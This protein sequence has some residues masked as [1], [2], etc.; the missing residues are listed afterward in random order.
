ME[1]ASAQWLTF[2]KKL[3][4]ARAATHPKTVDGVTCEVY[5]NLPAHLTPPG[6]SALAWTRTIRGGIATVSFEE[7]ADEAA[8]VKLVGDYE[9]LASLTRFIVTEQNEAE[10]IGEMD[11]AVRAGRITIVRETRS[12][13]P[14]DYTIHNLI[15]ALTR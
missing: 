4:L 7:C 12:D 5:R 14:R 15:G 1:F 2:L 11:K 13:E 3:L 8:D 6:K 9:T 10:F